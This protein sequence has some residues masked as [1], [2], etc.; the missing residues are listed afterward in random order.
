MEIKDILYSRRK[1]LDLTMKQVSAY[2]S[3]PPL[4]FLQ[5]IYRLPLKF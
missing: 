1:E 5:K 3:M 4:T 2:Y